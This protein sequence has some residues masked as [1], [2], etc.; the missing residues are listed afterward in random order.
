MKKV[1]E[2]PEI[3][4]H[5]LQPPNMDKYIHTGKKNSLFNKW[6]RQIG[7]PHTEKFS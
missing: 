6:C 2:D 3:G 1:G 4:S 7:D 5:Q